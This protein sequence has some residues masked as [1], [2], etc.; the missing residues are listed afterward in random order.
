MPDGER[1]TPSMT[2]AWEYVVS[3]LRQGLTSA[4]ALGEYRQGGG[5]VRTQDWYTLAHRAEGISDVSN[6]VLRMPED[7]SMPQRLFTPIDYDYQQDYWLNTRV[8]GRDQ[9]TGMYVDRWITFEF[10]A[11]PTRGDINAQIKEV[12]AVDTKGYVIT[13]Y[14]ISAVEAFTKQE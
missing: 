6:Y 11:P 8:Q 5:T 12:L 10:D 9:I 3:G 4:A 2:Q 14:A 1:W 7:M 13:D